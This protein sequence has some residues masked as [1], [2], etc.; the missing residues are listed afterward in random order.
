[1]TLLIEASGR[2]R[3]VYVERIDL[4]V[5]GI[6]RI[7]RASYVE[8]DAGGRW[9]VDLEPVGGPRLGPFERRSQALESEIGWL[10]AH[11][12]LG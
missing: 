5:L 3:C 12:L 6:P 8:P 4:Q 7:A 10:E 9:W 1:M 11:W 2:V